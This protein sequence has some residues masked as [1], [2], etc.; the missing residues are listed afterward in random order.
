MRYVMEVYEGMELQIHICLTS[1]L[2][3]GQAS[4]SRPGLFTLSVIVPGTHWIGGWVG[5]KVSLDDVM[6]QLLTLPILEFRRLRRP[7][8]SQ[9]LFRQHLGKYEAVLLFWFSHRVSGLVQHSFLLNLSL[10][11][12]FWKLHSRLRPG[13][14]NH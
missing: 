7:V 8:R 1:A 5:P 14:Q 6:G 3:G 11:L 13:Q 4:S 10:F 9:S 2:T 12:S